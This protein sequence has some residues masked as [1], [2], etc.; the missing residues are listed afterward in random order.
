MTDFDKSEVHLLS[1]SEIDEKDLVDFYRKTF[2]HRKNSLPKIWRWLNHTEFF[3][4]DIPFVLRYK[5]DL[6]GHIGLRPVELLIDKEYVLAGWPIDFRVDQRYRNHGLGQILSRRL[7]NYT[8]IQLAFPNVNSYPLFKKIGWVD[9]G[10]IYTHFMPIKPLDHPRFYA[11]IPVLIITLINVLVKPYFKARYKRLNKYEYIIQGITNTIIDEF[12]TSR[13]VDNANCIKEGII[14]P[15][16]NLE[17][18]KWRILASPNINKYFLFK[19]ETISAILLMNNNR[20]KYIDI[21]SVSSFSDLQ[22]VFDLV[23]SI[24]FFASNNNYSYVRICSSIDYLSKLL[25]EK[26]KSRKKE[27][28]FVYLIQDDRLKS[29]IA[30]YKWFWELIDSDF[31]YLEPLLTELQ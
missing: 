15:Q 2:P 31:E 20:G 12:V 19:T 22:Q 14:F 13:A 16:R 28:N 7:I 9:G 24:C 3:N 18:M 21:L 6:I 8:K 5:G 29:R 25:N 30:N 27:Y 11:K 23:A 4:N 17:Y 1:A 10:K 26:L